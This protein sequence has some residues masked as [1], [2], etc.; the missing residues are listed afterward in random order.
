MFYVTFC[1]KQKLRIT[2]STIVVYLA[3]LVKKL[4]GM[5]KIR[6]FSLNDPLEERNG[7]TAS[8]IYIQQITFV[9]QQ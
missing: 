6:K 2:S 3:S 9:I 7:L 5:K 4:K 1:N 8:I